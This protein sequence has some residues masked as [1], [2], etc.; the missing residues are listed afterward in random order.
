VSKVKLSP[1]EDLDPDTWAHLGQMAEFG[2]LSASLLHELRQ[3]LFAVKAIAQLARRRERALDEEGLKQLLLHVVQI[4]ELL[5]HYAGFGRLDEPDTVFDLN[6]PVRRAVDMLAHRGKQIGARVDF[7]LTDETLLVKGRPGAARQV[8]VNLLQNALDAVEGCT[9]REVLVQ[10][11]RVGRGARLVVQDNGP[12]VPED[13]REQL[14]KPFVT[15]KAPG[16]GTGLGLYIARKL[17]EE[18]MG[19]LNIAFPA[20]GGT[21]VEVVIP[22]AG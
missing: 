17:C 2:V 19:D 13:M 14:F 10:S 20:G 11:D 18:A 1:W 9:N 5:D 6:L 3:P 15:T 16:R 12:G 22:S 4:E 8:A 21:R 7:R